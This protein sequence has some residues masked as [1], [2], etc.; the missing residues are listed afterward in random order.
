MGVVILWAFGLCWA[1]VALGMLVRGPRQVQG[2]SAL[3]TVPLTFGSN[4]FVP[5]E[6]LPTWLRAW[7]AVFPLLFAAFLV[8]VVA[9]ASGSRAWIFAGGFAV[10]PP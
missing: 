2:L 1:F 5:T 8:L 7:V 10:L 3:V 9:P 4:V 6:T